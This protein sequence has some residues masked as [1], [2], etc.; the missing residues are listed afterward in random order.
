MKHFVAFLD[1]LG[2]VP[3]PA[4]AARCGGHVQARERPDDSRCGAG[5]HAGHRARPRRRDRVRNG[6]R[7]DCDSRRTD[8]RCTPSTRLRTRS[9]GRRP[10]FSSRNRKPRR[11]VGLPGGL[12]CERGRRSAAARSRDRSAARRSFVRIDCREKH[13]VRKVDQG[14]IVT[15]ETAARRRRRRRTSSSRRSATSRCSTASTSRS[16]CCM[17]ATAAC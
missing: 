11:A 13:I 1:A 6:E 17:S 4:R 8:A 7:A 10:A 2:V 9:F 14:N 12:L 5:G 15:L 3:I 16:T